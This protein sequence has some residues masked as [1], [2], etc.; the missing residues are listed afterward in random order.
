MSGMRDVG[1]VIARPAGKAGSETLLPA[2][3]KANRLLRRS[4]AMP[5]FSIT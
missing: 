2:L 3:S 1:A 5:F 4:M